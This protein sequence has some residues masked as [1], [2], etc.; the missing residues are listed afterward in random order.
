MQYIQCRAAIACRSE[1]KCEPLRV[2]VVVHALSRF[3]L[4]GGG[5]D[6]QRNSLD[7]DDEGGLRAR[8]TDGV[9][10]RADVDGDTGTV[11]P[12]SSGSL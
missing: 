4:H 5:Y 6:A 12:E 2:D 3:A 10:R 1:K 8:S 11:R 9:L 7:P